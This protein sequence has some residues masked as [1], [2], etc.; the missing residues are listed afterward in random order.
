MSDTA[1][2]P[3]VVATKIDKLSRTERARHLKELERGFGQAALPVS[4]TSNEGVDELW[5]LM[6]SLARGVEV[7]TGL[8]PR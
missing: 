7:K 8:H 1:A 2:A 6:A 4:V 3:Y 5:K